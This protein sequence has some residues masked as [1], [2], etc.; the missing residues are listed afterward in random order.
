LYR[1]ENM[2]GRSRILLLVEW[3]PMTAVLAL[4]RA[5]ILDGTMPS[6]EY[7]QVS[8][9]FIAVVMVLAIVLLRKLERTLI[10]WI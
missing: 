5:P 9:F 1:P 7:I 4:V 6:L 3:N 2:P 8:L 10:F